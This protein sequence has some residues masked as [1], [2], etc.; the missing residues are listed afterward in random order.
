MIAQD[1]SFCFMSTPSYYDIPFF[2]RAYVWNEENWSDLLS[3]LTNNNQNHFLGSIILKSAGATS[4]SYSRFSIIDGQQRLTT[5]SVLL[6]ACY[7][8]IE[9]N[10]VKYGYD[11]DVIKTCKVKMQELL[12]VSEGQIKPELHIKINHSR[13][14]KPSFESVING[15]LA[16]NDQW[17]QYVNLPDEDSTNNIIKAYAYFRD[18]LQEFSQETINDLWGLL[19]IDRIKFLVNIDLGPND[20]EQAIFDTINSAGVRL[21]SADTIKNLLFQK[22]VELLRAGQCYDI[23]K[24]AIE[25]YEKTWVDA[26]LSNDN[27]NA[28]WEAQRQYGR[29]KRRNIETFLHSFAVVKGFFNP[30]ENNMSDL[31]SEYRKAVSDMDIQE[32]K[33]FLKELHDYSDVYMDYFSNG[34]DSYTFDE[35][36]SRVF[37]IC[38]VLE[39][40][41]F[42]PY[43]LKQLYEK[44]IGRITEEQLKKD[45]FEIERYM[46][47]NAICKGSTKNYNNEC[48]QMVEGNKTP[49]EI[50]ESSVYI[51]E[52]SFSDGL[53]RMTTN[54]LPT[55][56]LFWIELYDRNSLNVDL[57][58]LK[59][60]YTLEHIMPQKWMQNWQDVT[61]YDIDRNEVE[62]PD[63]IERIRNH[64]IYEI[65]N[66]T[67]LNSKLNT[68]ISN[69]DYYH[70]VEG[71]NGKKGIRA[72]A[73]L[74][75]TR[76]VIDNNTEWNEL[77]IYDRTI[78]LESKI[79]EIWDAQNLPKETAIKVSNVTGGRRELRLRF[80][81]KA[82]PIIREKNN[83]ESFTNVA[84][85]TSN[86][87]HGYFGINGF[88]ISCVANYDMARV[89]FV[90]GKN[91]VAKNKEAYDVL[92]QHK[93]KIEGA[94]GEKLNWYRADENK[95]SWIT[96]R[97]EGVSISNETDW[98]KMADFLG[99]WSNKLRKAMVPYLQEHFPQEL[100]GGRSP[101]ETAKL[102][103]IEQIL[104]EWMVSKDE[105]NAC[106]EKST[107][108]SAKFTTTTMSEILPDTPDALS[109]W[110]VP[111][112]YFYEIINRHIT[113]VVIQLS[114][115][116]KNLSDEQRSTLNRIN[117]IVDKK[118]AK[119]DWAWWKA[120]K[121]DK[122]VIP[123]DLNRDVIF[124]NLDNALKFTLEFEKE[125]L[126]K[127][128]EHE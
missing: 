56:L 13:L 128:K 55:L 37:C 105:I 103:Q 99:E 25:E 112:H 127:L 57:K 52:T 28:Y 119:D 125:L 49:S 95:A 20:N 87:I 11:E 122:I 72:L 43:L 75:L 94:V 67:L 16:Q 32:L 47:L 74:R 58:S 104:K 39:V 80:W 118:Q 107:M 73:D 63:D 76:S 59:Y 27:T 85:S 35:Y 22:Y 96:Y 42:Y 93:N 114:F 29:M 6:R 33:T 78:A 41:T 17:E 44:Q 101:E 34:D 109:G 100:S 40:S 88:K 102:H 46:I 120:Y 66:M 36:I 53:R 92:L 38:N 60:D 45:F 71:K 126:E 84:P 123:D 8:H 90:L 2:Q 30:S 4:G 1:K 79:R 51:S 19:T 12:Y 26:F 23:D 70:K 15:E 21:S 3:N 89:E 48:L 124:S 106:L 61:A 97:L 117:G 14:D 86:D 110:K 31:P 98:D 9:K 18:E 50:L 5:L 24:E 121:T 83:N 77:K 62:D 91:D 54:K 82:L 64:A 68:S 7:D 111:N 69:S 65:G 116:S 81:D 115:N 108:T 10:A 113:H